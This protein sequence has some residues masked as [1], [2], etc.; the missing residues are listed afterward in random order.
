[1]TAE[2]SEGMSK[3]QSSSLLDL[4]LLAGAD[5]TTQTPELINWLNSAEVVKEA[6]GKAMSIYS[7]TCI[8][9]V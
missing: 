3:K 8:E 6:N 4:S 9:C 5:A 2:I 1:M 7:G